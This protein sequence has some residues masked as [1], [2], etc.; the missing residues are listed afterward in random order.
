MKEVVLEAGGMPRGS[1]AP[2][3]QTF[4]RRQPGIHH[5][6]AS[7]VSQTVTVG[8]DEAHITQTEIE[9]LIEECGHHCRG[10][11]VPAH[12]CA[13]AFGV[14]AEHRPPMPEPAHA[15]HAVKASAVSGT[16]QL[17]H[18]MGHGAG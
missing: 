17:A 16:A 12:L 18:E 2:A 7:A 13:P 15:G 5:A 1:S 6:E 10:E 4:L 14:A 3:L 9:R 11:V 8:Y